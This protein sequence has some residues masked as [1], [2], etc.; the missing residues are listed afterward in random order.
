[1]R[2]LAVFIGF[3]ALSG[4]AQYQQEQAELRDAG[5]DNQ[6]QSYGA[7]PG[8]DAYIQCRMNLSNQQAANRRAVIG[9]VLANQAA[10]Q[11]QPYVL[12]MP[13]PAPQPR[14]CT[15]MVNGQMI[16]TTCY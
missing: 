7:K 12:P 9:A 3:L 8:T 11:P 10:S 6:C 13:A 16:N 15:S 1:M 5:E 4:C 2:I 14:T